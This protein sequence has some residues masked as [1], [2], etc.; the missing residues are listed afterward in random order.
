MAAAVLWLAVSSISVWA[1]I[2]AKRP[3]RSD[4]LPFSLYVYGIG[5]I[6]LV[7]LVTAASVL[8]SP[9][10]PSTF[11]LSDTHDTPNIIEFI[12]DRQF[13]GLSL[14]EAQETLLR[15]I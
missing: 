10:E 9:R 12:R 6:G 3:E 1:V 7:I 11:S 4:W 8:A 5:L 14:S 15:A 13:L 2:Y